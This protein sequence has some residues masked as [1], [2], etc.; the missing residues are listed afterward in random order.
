MDKIRH[1]FLVKLINEPGPSGFED[2]VQNIYR[3]EVKPYCDEI[4]TDSN[5]N[6]VATL[7]PGND[8]SIMISGN[9]E[10]IGLIVN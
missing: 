9:A 7:N 2:N 1:Q 5:G 8:N 10:E 4:T 3:N 6:V